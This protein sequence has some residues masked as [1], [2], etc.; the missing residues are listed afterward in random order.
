MKS[1]AVLNVILPMAVGG[2]R[3]DLRKSHPVIKEVYAS[4]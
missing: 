3:G 4:N 2:L 1:E